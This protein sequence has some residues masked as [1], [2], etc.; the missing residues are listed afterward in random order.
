LF[1]NQKGVATVERKLWVHPSGKASVLQ[2]FRTDS[3]NK[4]VPVKNDEEIV[5]TVG[6]EIS[7]FSE[8]CERL[9]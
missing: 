6:Q 5:H 7:G 8:L 4:P 3:K 9:K 1:Q 2:V